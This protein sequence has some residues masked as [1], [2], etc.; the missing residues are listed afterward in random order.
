MF[1]EYNHVLIVDKNISG[2]IVDIYTGADGL[3][4]YTVQSDKAGYVDDPDAYPGLYPLYDCT[5][6]RLRLIEK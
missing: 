2:I 5:A 4:Y 1:D 6:S 3:V